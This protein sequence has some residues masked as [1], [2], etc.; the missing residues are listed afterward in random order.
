[1]SLLSNP[2]SAIKALHARSTSDQYQ[3][4]PEAAVLSHEN[5]FGDYYYSLPCIYSK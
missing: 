3:S 1:M 5:T 2:V 4:G